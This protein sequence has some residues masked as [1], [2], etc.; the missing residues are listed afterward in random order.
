MTTHSEEIARGD[1]FAF[2][3]NWA[4][5]LRLLT[6]ERIAM[7]ERSLADMLGKGT[8]LGKRFLD[9]GSGSGLFSLAARR[10][11]ATVHSF[12]YDPKSVACTQY[13]KQKYFPEDERWTVSTGSVL[14]LNFLG[15]LGKF[16]VVYSWGVLHHTGAMWEAMANVASLVHAGGH[17]FIAIYNDQGTTSKRWQ[18][19]KRTYCRLPRPLQIAV[20]PI[21]VVWLWGPTMLRDLLS[22]KPGA[23]WR[24]YGRGGARGMSPVVDVVDWLGGYPFEVAKPEDVFAFYRARNFHLDRL[25]TCGGGLGCNQFVFSSM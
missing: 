2:G 9:A 13:L 14:D 3:A 23:T 4:R 19:I 10:M 15:Q 1:R 20:V 17:L 24:Q 6:D 21:A 5:Y 7:A 11:G 8:L 22:G 12:D 25:V 18:V 16:D